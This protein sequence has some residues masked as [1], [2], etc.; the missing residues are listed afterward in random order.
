[1]SDGMSTHPTHAL[2]AEVEVSSGPSAGVMGDAGQ[3]IEAAYDVEGT[4][5]IILRGGYK[6]VS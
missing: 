4:A 1:M 3:S 2:E 5:E 6:T